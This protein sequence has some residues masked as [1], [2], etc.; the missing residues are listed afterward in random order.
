MTKM[1]VLFRFNFIS[2]NSM[3]SLFTTACSFKAHLISAQ[4]KSEIARMNSKIDYLLY[5]I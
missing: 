5:Y 4:I 3:I 1:Y 2:F